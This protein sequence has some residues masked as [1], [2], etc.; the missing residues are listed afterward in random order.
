MNAWLSAIAK[1]AADAARDSARRIA[2]AAT[3]WLLA[4]IFFLAALG[5]AVGSIYTAIANEVGPVSAGFIVAGG[6]LFLAIVFAAVAMIRSRRDEGKAPDDPLAVAREADPARP[7]GM[8]AV[9]ASFA[10][11]FARGLSRRRK[12]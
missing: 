1:T 7:G 3:L 10:Y 6:F 4:A 5:F 9:A 2:I 11:G 12:S 8:G